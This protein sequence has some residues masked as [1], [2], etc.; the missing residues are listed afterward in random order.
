MVEDFVR[1]RINVCLVRKM[2]K[3]KYQGNMQN[4]KG[5]KW[6][7]CTGCMQVLL[8]YVL[9]G[10]WWYF[11]HY[12]LPLVTL[13]SCI[14]GIF[15]LSPCNGMLCLV[16]ISKYDVLLKSLDLFVDVYL[17]CMDPLLIF[18]FALEYKMWV[19]D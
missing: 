9:D 16:V 7:K 8:I 17:L 11:P 10:S 4:Q 14:V 6:R 5:V 12:C 19:W 15:P 1:P 18:S 2:N 13:C 3:G